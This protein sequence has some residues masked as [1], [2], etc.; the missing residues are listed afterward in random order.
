MTSISDTLLS[1]NRM[2]VDAMTATHDR[3]LAS[4]RRAAAL[5]AKAPALP[6]WSTPWARPV[7]KN[8]LA[9]MFDVNLQAMNA[10]KRFALGLVEAWTPA[11]AR[12][13]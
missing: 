8:F 10:S 11:A 4:N 1:V 6:S 13:A 7:D 5:V 3:V 2:A 12:L 9:Q